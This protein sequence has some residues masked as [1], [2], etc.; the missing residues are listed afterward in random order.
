MSKRL[1]RI[2]EQLKR[3]I[4]QVL[5]REVRDPRVGVVTVSAVDVAADLAVAD[6][7]IR[8]L[9]SDDEVARSLEGLETAAPFVRRE[10]GKVLHLRQVPELRFREDRSLEHARRIEEILSRVLPG[11]EDGEDGADGGDAGPEGGDEGG[12]A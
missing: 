5:R 7:Y 11:E 8:M 12:G 1:A 3:E 2:N 6:V 10:L 9:G 4:S